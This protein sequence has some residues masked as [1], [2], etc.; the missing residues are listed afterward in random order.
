[1]YVIVTPIITEMIEKDRAKLERTL[2][3]R[4]GVETFS[5]ERRTKQKAAAGTWGIILREAA[6]ELL[7]V[8]QLVQPGAVRIG[9]RRRVGNGQLLGA[10]RH[11]HRR[12]LR[13]SRPVD[14]LQVQQVA[15]IC[16]LMMVIF[17]AAHMEST[18]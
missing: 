18:D 14:P 12:A 3:A 15:A 4:M 13:R 11:G 6:L 16:L 17:S 2:Q 8:A 5:S 1:M 7:L 10:A 9:G